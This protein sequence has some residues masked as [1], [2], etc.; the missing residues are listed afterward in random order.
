MYQA[1][2][3]FRPVSEK[4]QWLDHTGSTH[5]DCAQKV[6]NDPRLSYRWDSIYIKQVPTKQIG[7]AR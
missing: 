2:I 4:V 5:E 1:F 7:D 3:S 6:R